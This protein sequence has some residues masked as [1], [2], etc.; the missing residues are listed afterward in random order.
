MAGQRSCAGQNRCPFVHGL[1]GQLLRRQPG[2]AMVQQRARGVAGR[3]RLRHMQLDGLQRLAHRRHP[4]VLDRCVPERLR[5]VH[6]GNRGALRQRPAR[7]PDRN[8]CRHL[9]RDHAGRV[10]RRGGRLPASGGADFRPVDA[11]CQS[12]HRHPPARLAGHADGAAIRALVSL[13]QGTTRYHRLRCQSG[14]RA[15][16]QPAGDRSR[17][18]GGALRHGHDS[19]RRLPHRPV[20]PDAAIRRTGSRGLGGRVV[21]SPRGQ[22][23]D[24]EPAERAEQA[25]QL[26]AAGESDHRDRRSLS[27]VGAAAGRPLHRCHRRDHAGR[28]GGAAR[29]A[30]AQPGRPAAL[31]SAMGQLRFLAAPGRQRPRRT[32]RASMVCRSASM[33]P[34]RPPHRCSQRQ[35]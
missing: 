6:A 10:G 24:L 19:S 26:P 16:T 25:S 18:P 7:R 12:H 22:R 8:R 13:P 5:V 33:G 15:E 27:P 30:A 17:R 35:P 29:S 9:R 4:D 2:S 3:Q 1:R 28:L 31:V 32:Q 11:D 14:H 20:R 21:V 34:L 23:P